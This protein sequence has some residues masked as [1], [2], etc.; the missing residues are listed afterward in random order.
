M[1]IFDISSL[2]IPA[3]HFVKNEDRAIYV[4]K[5]DQLVIPNQLLDLPVGL[6]RLS[7]DQILGYLSDILTDNMRIIVINGLEDDMD[8]IRCDY[9]LTRINIPSEHYFCCIECKYM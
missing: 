1:K 4:R 6:V 3:I 8:Y 7:D 9:C 5:P 2:N